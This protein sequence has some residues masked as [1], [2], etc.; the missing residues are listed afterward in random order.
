[1]KILDLK[2]IS[3]TSTHSIG[4]SKKIAKSIY[5]QGNILSIHFNPVLKSFSTSMVIKELEDALQIKLDPYSTDSSFQSFILDPPTLCR[6]LITNKDEHT[7]IEITKTNITYILVS[8]K[9]QDG[10][11]EE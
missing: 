3:T 6:I 4:I 11:Q 10:E 7:E 8:R 9:T 2:E 5:M 1:M